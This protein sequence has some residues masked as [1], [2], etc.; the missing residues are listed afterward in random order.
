MD[1]KTLSSGQ[2]LV[3]MVAKNDLSSAVFGVAEVALDRNLI[4]G[5]VKDLPIVG[6]LV[7]LAKAGQSI[8][9]AMFIRKLERFLVGM[10]EVPIVEREKLLAKYP[11]CSAEQRVLGE[12]LLLALE[13][14]DD[15]EKP[16]ILARFFTA[17]MKSEIDHT[18]FTRLARALEK[19]NMELLPN[20][21]WFYTR[22]QSEVETPE[23]VIHELS[24]AGLVLVQ[25]SGSGTIGG[26]AG[27]R[28][29]F[30]GR[31]FLHLGFGVQI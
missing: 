27:Y 6:I 14:L 10:K 23:E 8:S 24:L 12:N 18:T 29:S 21:R 16:N 2:S 25:L 11:D 17:Y 3:S 28:Q 13:R 1:K 19:F 9:E 22:Q 26:S 15:V 7:N 4:E 30:L 5:V 31:S 20:L